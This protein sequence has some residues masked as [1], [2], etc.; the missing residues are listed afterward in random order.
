MT[1]SAT[2]SCHCTGEIKFSRALTQPRERTRAVILA[3]ISEESGEAGRATDFIILRKGRNMGHNMVVSVR[4]RAGLAPPLHSQGK[5]T[6]TLAC[7]SEES[8]EAG[9]SGGGSF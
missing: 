1:S 7:I 3:S 4:E 9:R 6:A 5:R 2:F 8:E